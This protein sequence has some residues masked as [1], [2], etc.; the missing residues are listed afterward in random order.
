MRISRNAKEWM[1]KIS[2]NRLSQ[3]IP[4]RDYSFL[5]QQ[6][7]Q[8]RVWLPFPAKKAL[9]EICDINEISLTE[10]LTEYFSTYLFGYHEMLRMRANNTGLYEPKPVV[11]YCAMSTSETPEPPE[12]HLG[13]NIFALKIW[14]PEKIKDGLSFFADHAEV[15]L[16]EF[17]RALICGHLFGRN[18]APKEL[19]SDSTINA[20]I[21]KTW[22]NESMGDQN[23]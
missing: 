7:C 10:H 6:G 18:Y 17:C 19:M 11:R 21:A 13:K 20:S 5:N 22:E 12:P 4:P 16:G 14:I 15:S 1:Q 23:F 9:D 8:L 3:L 2:E